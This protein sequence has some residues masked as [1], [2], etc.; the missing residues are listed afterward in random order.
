MKTIIHLNFRGFRIFLPEA[1][2]KG[3]SNSSLYNRPLTSSLIFCFPMLG[4]GFCK[5][6]SLASWV[7][8][9]LWQRDARGRLEG[10]K[11]ESGFTPVYLPPVFCLFLSS[12]CEHDPCCNSSFPNSKNQPYHARLETREQASHQELPLLLKV[13]VPAPRSAPCAHPAPLLASL[14]H[15]LQTT[16]TWYFLNGIVWSLF[17]KAGSY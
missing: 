15:A 14:S 10:G 7:P 3:Q 6:F 12:F 17:L 8:A 2:E 11:R 5:T 4:L 13:W 9:R 16:D 1:K